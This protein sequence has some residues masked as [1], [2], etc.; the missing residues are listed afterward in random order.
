[1]HN[2]HAVLLLSNSYAESGYTPTSDTETFE[3]EI[4]TFE[5]LAISDV[6]Q[7]IQ[8]AFVKPF[9]AE[10]K[11]VVIEAKGIAR[12]AQHALLKIFE[13][14]PLSTKFI[15]VLPGIEGLLP[16]VLSRVSMPFGTAVASRTTNPFFTIFE[17]SSIASRLDVISRITKDKDSDQIELLRS[18]VLWLLSRT[19]LPPHAP[20]LAYCVNTMNVRGASKKMLLEEIALLLPMPVN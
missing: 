16:T 7:I 8:S 15:L 14:P 17:S 19:P 2:H 12:E 13:E 18:G 1:M 11:I 4:S 20:Q 5:T 10:V 9:A 6:R 3:I